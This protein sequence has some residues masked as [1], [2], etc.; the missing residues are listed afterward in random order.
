[1]NYSELHDILREAE[2]RSLLKE[3][4]TRRTFIRL[5]GLAGGGL[6]IGWLPTLAAEERGGA[7][8]DL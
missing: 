2:G 3:P 1:M 5:S 7:A 6:A 4:L 8:M